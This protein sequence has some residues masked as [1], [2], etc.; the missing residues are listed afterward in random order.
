MFR[1]CCSLSDNK[2]NIDPWGGNGVY[3]QLL[4]L[5]QMPKLF[6]KQSVKAHGPL[7]GWYFK[8]F[9]FWMFHGYLLF[10]QHNNVRRVFVKDTL[11]KCSSHELC[12]WLLFRFTKFHVINTCSAHFLCNVEWGLR[13]LDLMFFLFFFFWLGGSCFCC[14]TEH[15][16]VNLWHVRFHRI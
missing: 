10:L 16:L 8:I 15:V 14:A 6:L 3:V 2:L 11:D 1:N 13:K 4:E 7:V 5:W 12:T 9:Q